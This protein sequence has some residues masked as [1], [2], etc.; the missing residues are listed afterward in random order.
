MEGLSRLITSAKR[1]GNISGLKIM[2]NFDLT[3]L[4]F[5]DDILIFINES[6]RDTTSLNEILHLFCSATGMEINRGKSSISLSG[7]TNH[8]TQLAI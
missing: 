6:V 4:L 7:C 5:V 1:S 3:H 8:E 2:E